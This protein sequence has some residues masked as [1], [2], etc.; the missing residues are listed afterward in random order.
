MSTPSWV[1]RL[2]LASDNQSFR[3]P[4]PSLYIPDTSMGLRSNSSRSLHLL[5]QNPSEYQRNYE[6]SSVI[7]N[8]LVMRDVLNNAGYAGLNIGNT[9][10]NDSSIF[11]LNSNIG[12]ELESEESSKY[13]NPRRL[14]DFRGKETYPQKE[15]RTPNKQMH[16]LP[17]HMNQHTKREPNRDESWAYVDCEGYTA[18]SPSHSDLED[19]INIAARGSCHHQLYNGNSVPPSSVDSGSRKLINGK[20]KDAF[21]NESQTSG[22]TSYSESSEV[23]SCSRNTERC[24]QLRSLQKQSGVSALNGDRDRYTKAHKRTPKLQDDKGISHRRTNSKLSVAE[25]DISSSSKERKKQCEN[26]GS[27]HS[28][29]SKSNSEFRG[30]KTPTIGNV[31]VTVTNNIQYDPSDPFSFIQPVAI[32]FNVKVRKCVGPM[33]AVIL[34]LILAAALGAAIY[35]ASALKETRAAQ[36]DIL[37]ANLAFRIKSI[38][39]VNNIDTLTSTDFEN[40][41]TSYCK[42]MDI[43]YTRSRFRDTYRGCEVISM[44]KSYLNF[45]LFFVEKEVTSDQ[46]IGVIESSANRTNVE[47]KQLAFVDMF[48]LEL[49]SVEIRMDRRMEAETF[50]K[51]I[52]KIFNLPSDANVL[53][54]SLQS[55]KKDVITT[56][57]KTPEVSTTPIAAIAMKS[58]KKIPPTDRP[59]YS[60]DPCKEYI[61]IYFPHP[62][63]CDMFLQCTNEQTI[64]QNCT[65]GLLYHWKE[66]TCVS[67]FLPNVQCPDPAKAPPFPVTIATYATKPSS[68]TVTQMPTSQSTTSLPQIIPVGNSTTYTA[69]AGK[70]LLRPKYP[71]DPCSSKDDV[72]L[73]PHPDDCARF[74]QCVNGNVQTMNCA[75]GLVFDP[76]NSACIFPINDLLCPDIT[77]CVDRDSG[78][79]PHPYNCSRF[80]QCHTKQQKIIS[81]QNDLIWNSAVNSCVHRINSTVCP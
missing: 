9:S 67:R 20:Q 76:T 15:T 33:L 60:W 62:T 73:Y 6:T 68:T 24:D 52:A 71:Q 1:K 7:S 11:Q 30:P 57:M 32:P 22:Y 58:E 59:V 17:L 51:K 48:E 81:C 8:T 27:T 26:Y 69:I 13:E 75:P 25:S 34:L 44:Q 56:K 64:I 40:L 49:D 74:I 80:I 18:T 36:I 77:P 21:T 12:D 46:V 72:N 16:D 65:N 31:S 78:Y 66:L 29:D 55:Y 23:A 63:E 53:N 70:F 43:Y 41:S 42:Q 54:E 5:E 37:R 19:T 50:N 4:S 14:R 10:D 3:I 47:T 39:H 45:T 2:S 38:E 28:L 79:F 61:G 35:F